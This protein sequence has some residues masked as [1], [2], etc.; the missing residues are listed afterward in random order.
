MK[1]KLPRT[2]KT[3]KSYSRAYLDSGRTHILNFDCLEDTAH[4]FLAWGIC[5][6]EFRATGKQYAHDLVSED[7]VSCFKCMLKAGYLKYDSPKTYTNPYDQSKVQC[8]K[9]YLVMISFD[10]YKVG[11]IYTLQFQS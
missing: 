8:G 1:T 9:Y 2:Y 3:L 5:G 10:N 4:P 11:D 7:G 6:T